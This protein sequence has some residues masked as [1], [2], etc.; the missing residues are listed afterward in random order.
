MA[1]T[2]LAKLL[3][4]V[5]IY[6]T[7]SDFKDAKAKANGVDVF[8]TH[9]NF[10]E[11][12][13]KHQFDLILATNSGPILEFYQSLLKPLGRL[14]ILGANNIIQNENKLS[15]MT[16][17]KLWWTTKNISPESLVM[18]NRVVAGLHL[19]TLMENNLGKI[20]ETLNHIFELLKEGKIKPVVDSIWKLNEIVQATKILAERKNIGKVLL[21]FGDENQK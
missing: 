7:G 15:M 10:K 19:G 6:G 11:G 16:L 8:I 21:K 13:K 3:E 2:Q 12:I 9:E 18:H 20:R 14:V 17:L 4:G 1:A 5:E